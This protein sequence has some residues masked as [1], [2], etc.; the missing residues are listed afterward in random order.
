MIKEKRIQVY[1]DADVKRKLE[2]KA[3]KQNRSISNM[4]AQIL[5]FE[6][7]KDENITK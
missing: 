3:N 6:L 2:K 1:I 7:N 4:A 5:T